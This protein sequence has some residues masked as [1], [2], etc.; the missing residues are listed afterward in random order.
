MATIKPAANDKDAAESCVFVVEKAK[1][2]PR[3]FKFNV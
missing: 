3:D 2:Y 1:Q